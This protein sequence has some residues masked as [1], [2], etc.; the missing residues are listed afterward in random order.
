VKRPLLF[1]YG[2]IA[3]FVCIRAMVYLPAFLANRLVPKTID[4]GPVGPAGVA[5]SID[6]GLLLL[7]VVPHSLMARAAWKR[8]ISDHL[9]PAL[10]RSTYSLAAAL[11]IV[12]LCWQWRPMPRP[13]WSVTGP[14]ATALLVLSIAGWCTAAIAVLTLGNFHLFGLRQ[15]WRSARDEPYLAPGLN[16]RRLYAWLRHPMYLGFLVG[17]WAT[18]QMSQGHALFGVVMTGYVVLGLH[19]EERDLVRRFGEDYERY[20]SEVP[21]FVPRSP[22]RTTPGAGADRCP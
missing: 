1:A 17:V 8:W 11:F 21:R 10:E 12:L 22:R 3:Y 16:R 14:A 18:P 19:Y 13:L 9:P 2:L 4:S 5:L 7:F 20:R 6:L 15:A